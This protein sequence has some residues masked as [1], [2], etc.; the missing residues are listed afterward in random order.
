VI[1]SKFYVYH[2]FRSGLI[3]C[4]NLLPNHFHFHPVRGPVAALLLGAGCLAGCAPTINLATPKPVTVDIGVRLDIYQ[5]T[6]PTKAKDEQ[7]AITVAK[8]RR[9]RSGQIQQLKNDRVV[10]EDRDGYLDLRNPPTDPKYLAYAKGII[11]DENADRSFLYLSNAQ[12]QSKPLEEIETQYAQLWRSR[13]FPG[14]W[15][16]KDDGTWTQK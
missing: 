14:E 2:P 5:K 4:V 6:P 7:S 1:A 3:F 16:Q 12:G 9:L 13:A 11:S 10:G 15:I 8:D